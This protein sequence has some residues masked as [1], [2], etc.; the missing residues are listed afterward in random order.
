M[1]L[2]TWQMYVILLHKPNS[3]I[4]HKQDKNEADKKEQQNEDV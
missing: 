2:W 4:P 1:H 3:H